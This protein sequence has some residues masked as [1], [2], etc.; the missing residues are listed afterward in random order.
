MKR[1]KNLQNDSLVSLAF[2]E[3]KKMG[4]DW[5]RGIKPILEIDQTFQM[6]H[7][8]AFNHRKGKNFANSNNHSARERNDFIL[9]KGLKTRIPQPSVINP[10]KCGN[11]LPFAILKQLKQNFRTSWQACLNSFSKLD[12]YC[13]IKDKFVKEAYLDIVKS[14]TDRVSLTRLRISA[15]TLEVETGRRQRIP[16][17][18]RFCKWCNISLGAHIVENE[19]HFL[20]QCDLNAKIRHNLHHKLQNLQ[21][22]L[23]PQT[24]TNNNIL[25]LTSHITE[26]TNQLRYQNQCHQLRLIARFANRCF[27]ERQKFLAQCRTPP[28]AHST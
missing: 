26:P 27:T 25:A 2:K 19:S 24:I 14:Y 20:N 1:I 11:F 23:N 13:T 16:R 3:Q 5:Y 8:T 4:L 17:E 12:T 22:S 21:A 18:G 10:N 7:V 28:K 6:D 15:H 9:H